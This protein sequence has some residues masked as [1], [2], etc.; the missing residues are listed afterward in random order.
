MTQAQGTQLINE[1]VK[2]GYKIDDLGSFLLAIAV[3]FA[4]GLGLHLG[5]AAAK[6]AAQK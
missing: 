4:V 2:L 5:I 6:L 1:V 3:V